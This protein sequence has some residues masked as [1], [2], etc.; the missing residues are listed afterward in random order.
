MVR[1]VA[2]WWAVV[3]LLVA[4][5]VAAQ[6]PALRDTASHGMMGHA[7]PARS[8]GQPVAPGGMAHASATG[9]AMMAGGMTAA[10]MSEPGHLLEQ[11]AALG[12]TAEQARRLAAIRDAA[13]PGHDA[14]LQSG[15]LRVRELELAMRAAAPDTEAVRTQAEAAVAAMGRAHVVM[16]A[17]AAQAR[18]VLTEAQRRQVDAMPAGMVGRPSP[19]ASHRH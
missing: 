4:A 14:A 18:A 13:R 3:A 12:L 5:P 6:Q 1:H 19:A 7:M 15:Q 8:A 17:A 2:G 16:L 9:C 10:M 11:R